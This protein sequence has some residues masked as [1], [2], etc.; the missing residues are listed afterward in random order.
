[1]PPVERGFVLVLLT[2]VIGHCLMILT[3]PR[4]SWLRRHR[5]RISTV[6]VVVLLVVVALYLFGVILPGFATID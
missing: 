5:E 2:I 1:V 3:S 4:I 6:L